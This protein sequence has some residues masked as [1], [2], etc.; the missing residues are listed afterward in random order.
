MED[1]NQPM[2]AAPE[3][4]E[5]VET[6]A[7][8]PQAPAKETPEVVADKAPAQ[9]ERTVP[10]SAM[11]EERMR[12]QELQRKLAEIEARSK[13]FQPQEGDLTF[14]Q[15]YA[16][17]FVQDLL[18][19]GAERDLKDFTREML[20]QYPQIPEGVKKAILKNPRGF[21]QSTTTDVENAK[22]DIQEY[23]EGLL[24]GTVAPPVGKAVQVAPTNPPVTQTSVRPAEIEK[25]LQKPVEEMSDE[26][27]KLV[28][29]YKKSQP[30]R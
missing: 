18:V 9:P 17:P 7:S 12:R 2:D 26:E 19:K 13:Q 3:A 1:V 5:V 16:H 27:I 11:R 8:E 22:L 23:V 14:E 24:D 21:V 28:D 15:V 10:Y 25:I 6:P 20:D 30:K 29:E 4:A